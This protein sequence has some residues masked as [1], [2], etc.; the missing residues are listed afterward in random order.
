MI[1]MVVGLPQSITYDD[2]VPT[3]S[4]LPFYV[5][6]LGT[7]IG[8]GSFIMVP[9]DEGG[10]LILQIRSR[11]VDSST[12]SSVDVT[13]L[14]HGTLFSLI[15][16]PPP[17]DI[18]SP[19]TEGLREVGMRP[20]SLS[21]NLVDIIEICFIFHPDGIIAEAPS[22]FGISNLFICRSYVDCNNKVLDL[23]NEGF[24]SFPSDHHTFN[25]FTKCYSK[26]I[27]R[28]LLLVQDVLR[29][30]LSSYSESQGTFC[31]TTEKVVV[32]SDMF[33]Y[34]IRRLTHLVPNFDVVPGK[35]KIPKQTLTLGMRTTTTS[36]IR[37]TRVVSLFKEE[38][39]HG[40]GSLFGSCSLYG[41]RRRRPK[42]SETRNLQVQDILNVIMPTYDDDT[43]KDRG[44]RLVFDGSTLFMYICYSSYVY[45]ARP[46][47]AE[48]LNCPTPVLA[49]IIQ[50]GRRVLDEEAESSSE[51]SPTE[52]RGECIAKFVRC[53]RI[54]PHDGRNVLKIQDVDVRNETVTCVVVS[55]NG[56]MSKGTAVTLNDLVDVAEKI[57]AY[58]S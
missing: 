41:N 18:A 50:F 38:C 44:I 2:S 49:N 52:D 16:N 29:T 54:F 10:F 51:D 47:T 14:Y 3:Y 32:S 5:P 1:T 39:L 19:L 42:K 22:A 12:R 40:F 35:K 25:Q 58:N 46:T 20:M 13:Y 45:D 24:F 7:Y 4:E 57:K 36:I 26:Q 27:W 17:L 6:K 56:S 37:N 28:E 34:I 48:V 8:F 43:I 23:T 21:F 33:Q 9:G 55:K 30:R 53:G 11:S 31:R 15:G